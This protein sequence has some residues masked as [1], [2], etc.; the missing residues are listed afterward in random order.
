VGEIRLVT[1]STYAGSDRLRAN[2]I[3]SS[4]YAEASRLPMRSVVAM[5]PMGALLLS[6][7]RVLAKPPDF[8]PKLALAQP[9]R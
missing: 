3:Q 8:A 4:N 5:R 7:P 2:A 1:S 9:T 6:T